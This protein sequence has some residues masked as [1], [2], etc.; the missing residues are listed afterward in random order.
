MELRHADRNGGRDKDVV[1]RA[2]AAGLNVMLNV[3]GSLLAAWGGWT[4]FK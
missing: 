2:G 1:G 3:L 4:L